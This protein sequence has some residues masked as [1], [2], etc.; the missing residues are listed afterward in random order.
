MKDIRDLYRN[1]IVEHYKTPHNFK[2][3][4]NSNRQAQG[5]NVLCGDKF[6]VFLY[7]DNKRI[8]DISF[9]GSGCAVAT[10][11]ASLMTDI[12]KGKTENEAKTIFQDFMDLLSG[13]SVTAEKPSLGELNVFAG[14]RGYPARI[15][16]AFL[17]WQTFYAAL[18][19]K[20]QIEED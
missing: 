12:L 19:G 6:S 7:I 3:I 18:E 5:H 15:K 11:S 14:V 1:T 4:K 9:I 10:A 16:C 8:T 13:T 17:A 20:Q 2:K